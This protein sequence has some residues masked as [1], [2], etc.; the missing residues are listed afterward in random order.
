[1]YL[2]FLNPREFTYIPPPQVSSTEVNP[3]EFTIGRVYNGP[4]E[5]GVNY[6][7]HFRNWKI[8]AVI[9]YSLFITYLFTMGE[10]CKCSP[11]KYL[12]DLI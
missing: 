12:F 9:Y 5:M 3:G 7:T 2:P 11:T 6:Y 4:G 10:I 8:Q 1:M